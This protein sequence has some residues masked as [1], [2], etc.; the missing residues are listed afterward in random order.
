M[1]E[2]FPQEL[3]AFFL[4]IG[5]R[6]SLIPDYVQTFEEAYQNFPDFYQ[7][8]IKTS[9]VKELEKIIGMLKHLDSL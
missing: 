4:K 7:K 2:N 3:K 5:K 1:I 6:H 9:E 8:V